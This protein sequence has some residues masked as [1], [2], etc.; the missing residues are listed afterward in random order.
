MPAHGSSVISAMTS[1]YPARR[2]RRPGIGVPSET[3][4]ARASTDRRAKKQAALS[5][6]QPKP[7]ATQGYPSFERPPSDLGEGLPSRPIT[8]SPVEAEASAGD[9]LL[10]P[11]RRGVPIAIRWF[12]GLPPPPDGPLFCSARRP[13][14]RADGD[15][16]SS[17]N[18]PGDSLPSGCPSAE[19]SGLPPF[20]FRW[21]R[22]GRGTFEQR[23][24]NVNS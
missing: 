8:P 10:R 11:S 19:A 14:F 7:F 15:F 2:R 4:H 3:L 22:C 23:V 21:D 9:A 1:P 5:A 18:S 20:T 6:D 17:R 24:T 16:S 13:L 12:S